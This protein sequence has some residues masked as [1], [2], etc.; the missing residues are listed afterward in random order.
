MWTCPVCKA[1]NTE[2][3]VCPRCQYRPSDN[4]EQFPTLSRLPNGVQSLRRRRAAWLATAGEGTL[5]CERCGGIAFAVNLRQHSC[6]CLQCGR[7]VGIG[8]G[9]VQPVGAFPVAHNTI[10]GGITYTAAIR[11]D[12]TLLIT[13]CPPEYRNLS[14]AAEHWDNLV[15]IAAGD[16][17]LLGL[18]AD[19]TVLA[20]GDISGSVRNTASWRNIVAVSAG[21]THSAGLVADGTVVITDAAQQLKAQ[22]W[23][24][25]I[26]IAAGEDLTLA[27]FKDGRVDISCKKPRSY[28]E[29]DLSGWHDIIAICAR[30]TQIAGVRK[31]GTVLAIGWNNYRQYNVQNWTDITA[32]AI[33]WTHT[34]GLRRDGTVVASGYNFDGQCNVGQWSQIVAIYACGHHTLGLRADGTVVATGA[35]YSGQCDV[36]SWTEIQ[37]ADAAAEIRR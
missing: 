37:T 5:V 21:T 7:K 1:E 30:N 25:V 8:G 12:G 19:G 17:Y 22:H 29:Y 23:K 20:A 32:V 16:Y 11:R 34:V 33:G 3:R 9:W 36:T 2:H 24:N 31:D 13:K 18:R 15:S 35:D 27:L 14:Y 10:A 4:F 6:S 26:A 28:K